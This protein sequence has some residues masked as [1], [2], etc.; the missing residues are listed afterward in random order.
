MGH[1]RRAVEDG[2]YRFSSHA[3]E[4]ADAEQITVADIR[5][6]LLTGQIVEDYPEHRRGPCCLVY[7]RTS[8]DKD[9]H[10]VITTGR[11]PLTI[12]T[13]TTAVLANAH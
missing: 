4:E 5:E 8:A 6:A 13:A 7:G 2:Q 11:L 1:I 3:D 12:V 9:I 10:V